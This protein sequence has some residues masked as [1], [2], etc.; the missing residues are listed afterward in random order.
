MNYIKLPDEVC[1]ECIDFATLDELPSFSPEVDGCR[2]EKE[3][4]LRVSVKIWG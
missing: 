1:E 4:L 2:V 3:I